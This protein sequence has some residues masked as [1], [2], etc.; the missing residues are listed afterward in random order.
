MSESKIFCRLLIAA[1]IA[2][3]FWKDVG[4]LGRSAALGVLL[5]SILPRVQIRISRIVHTVIVVLTALVFATSGFSHFLS[6]GLLGLFIAVAEYLLLIQALELIRQPRPSTANYVPGLSVLTLS[7]LVMSLDEGFTPSS[8]GYM[9]LV[10]ILLLVLTLRPDLPAMWFAGRKERHKAEVLLMIFGAAIVAGALFQQELRQDL[11]QLRQMIKQLQVSGEEVEERTTSQ[12]GTRLVDRIVLGSIAQTQLINP[13]EVAF[14]VN[15]TTTPGYM[16]TTAFV[17]FDGK[18]WQ[19]PWSTRRRP[20]DIYTPF[21]TLPAELPSNLGDFPELRRDKQVFLF[22]GESRGSF[23]KLVVNIPDGR[24]SLIPA[25]LH[26]AYLLGTPGNRVQRPALDPHQSIISNGFDNRRYGL[27][28]STS[29]RSSVD[30]TYL[31]SLLDVPDADVALLREVSDKVTKGQTTTR[32]KIRAV[33]SYFR[34]NFTYSLQ[35]NLEAN[36]RGRSQLRAFLEDRRQAHCEYFATA[37][38]LLLRSQGIP[39]RMAAGY[40]VYEKNDDGEYFIA[41]NRNA[42]AWVEAY[43]AQTKEW[44]IVEATP[45]I[46]EYIAR[47]N[48]TAAQKNESGTNAALDENS[49]SLLG[50]FQALA[51][52]VSD[53]WRIVIGSRFAWLLPLLLGGLLVALRYRLLGNGRKQRLRNLVSPEIRRADKLASKL[54][55]QRAPGETCNQF[56]S[57]LLNSHPDLAP[58]AQWYRE[59]S[60]TR[61]QQTGC[62]TQPVPSIRRLRQVT[63]A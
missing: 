37:S 16:R 11:P 58:L 29:H 7:L 26:T 23:E 4:H 17:R 55:F 25:P 48:A 60:A 56:A 39:C 15:A 21:A 33:E 35:S 14:T 42:H 63:K 51:A 27:L 57:R 46:T 40:L 62:V 8:L 19:N 47:F 43:D 36:L 50:L 59:Y 61:Y 24:G 13:K 53:W 6:R 9:Y 20:T 41:A 18:Q 31:S 1:Q 3:C 34:D 2:I 5:L 28:V 44:L 52:I 54:G 32:Q 45:T 30:S 38:A 49:W 22:P 10:F 12:G